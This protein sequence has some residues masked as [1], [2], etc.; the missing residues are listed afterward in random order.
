MFESKAGILWIAGIGFFALSFV[1]NAV[2]PALMYRDL[3][4]QTVEE[5]INSNIRYQFEDMARRYPDSFNEAYGEP[6]GGDAE[7]DE[8]W[9]EKC[10][11]ALEYGHKIYV[12]EGC[13]HC[14]SQFVRPVSNEEQRWGP[15]AESW[16][17]QN[18]R[19]RPVMFGTRRVGPDL[20]RE[21]GRRGNDWHAV[22]FYR[23][24]TLSQGSPMPEYPWFFEGSPDKPNKRGLAIM[25]YVQWLGSWQESYPYYEDYEPSFEKPEEETDEEAAE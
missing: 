4:E 24:K 3:P 18:E 22:H 21:G 23:P 15:V 2:V 14:H 1:S 11:E 9:N 19:N 25:T 13:W 17:Y 10:A 6:P 20:S 8:W 16:E 5:L 12:G 7:H